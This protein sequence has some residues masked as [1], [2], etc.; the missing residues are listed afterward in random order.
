MKTIFAHIITF[1]GDP[2]ILG[3][4]AVQEFARGAIVLQNSK[5]IWVGERADLPSEYAHAKTTDYGKKYLMAGFIDP[6]LHFPQYR[7][8]AA[9]GKNL[10]DWLTRFTF[11][12]EAR[13]ADE[14]HAQNAAD[15]FLNFLLSNGTT[16]VMAFSSVHKVA[17]N[18]LFEA[19]EKRNMAL[20]TGKTMMDRNAPESVLDEAEIGGIESE[21]LLQKWHGKG[22]LRY[23]ITPRFALT[24]TAAQ[25]QVSSELYAKYPDCYMQTH[26]SESLEEI[27]IVKNLFPKAKDYTDVYDQ[28]DLL[29][30]N[31][32]FGHSIY[33][34]ERECIRLSETGSTTVHC[35][36]S[37][38]F[39]GSGLMNIAKMRLTSR[40]VNVALATDIG[41]G[42]SYSMLHTIGEAFKVASLNNESFGAFEGFYMASLGNA[43]HLGMDGEMGSIKVGNWADFII[44]DPE[45][46][47]LLE[48][49][50]EISES[51]EDALFA[52]A[53]LGDDRAIK[54]TYVAGECLHQCAD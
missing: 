52:L 42:T 54:A 31:S 30:K 27:E 32:F 34:N 28:F 47:P 11:K 10:M 16:S 48:A 2:Q 18:A 43:K 44:I 45:A 4:K 6:H 25:L 1:I 15:K 5:I 7:M 22:R 9:P 38:T 29:G 20:Y 17:A 8:L 39:L 23:A 49:R 37:N 12:E 13:Y 51:T 3:D 24:S 19:A 35:P 53:I 14:A 26:L 41:G 21:E 46:T 50:Q 40:P 33:L 36:T